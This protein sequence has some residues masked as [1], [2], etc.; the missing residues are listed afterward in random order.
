MQIFLA[1]VVISSWSEHPLQRFNI[2]CSQVVRH[3]LRQTEI[4][5][6]PSGEFRCL[7]KEMRSVPLGT[8]P[9]LFR[10]V[11]RH[12]RSGQQ[13]IWSQ[14]FAGQDIFDILASVMVSF[15]MLWP[16]TTKR[17]HSALIHTV[18]FLH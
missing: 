4:P 11:L 13:G 10:L 5:L 17:K 16:S 15:R 14:C 6:F 12:L 9:V 1:E 8:V 3:H 7:Q 2:V 18:T